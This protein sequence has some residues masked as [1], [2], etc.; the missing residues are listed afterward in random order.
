MTRPVWTARC[1]S[2]YEYHGKPCRQ[3]TRRGA[4]LC[5]GCLAAEV[6][7]APRQMSLLVRVAGA[8]AALFA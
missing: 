4:L 7:P 6:V 5:D 1:K 8:L 2:G 3:A